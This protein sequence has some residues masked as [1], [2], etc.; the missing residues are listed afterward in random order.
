[1]GVFGNRGRQGL[2][3]EERAWLVTRYHVVESRIRIQ[4]GSDTAQEQ[5]KNTEGSR[6]VIDTLSRHERTERMRRIRHK[7]TRPEW[8]ARRL[9]HSLGLRYR[10]HP[11][12]LPGKPDLVLPRHKAVVFVHGCFWHRHPEPSCRLARWPKSRLEF[13][14]PK[15]EGNRDRDI[16]IQ[17]EL[18][19]LGWRVLV[20]WECELADARRLEARVRAFFWGSEGASG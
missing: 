20:L 10:L 7:D 6:F 12:T 15:L 4:K 5:N 17:E 13:W 11:T 14:R 16:R 19:R 8:A 2:T 9:L 18:S 1:M 3:E